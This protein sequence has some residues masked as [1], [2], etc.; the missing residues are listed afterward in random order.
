MTDSAPNSDDEEHA[1][2]YVGNVYSNTAT[3]PPLVRPAKKTKFAPWHHPVKQIVRDYQWGDLTFKL[4]QSREE[5]TRGTLRYF[6]L[7]GADLL[8]VRYLSK[9]LEA[10]NSK[11]E[12][13]GFN[14][15]QPDA[16]LSAVEAEKGTYFSAETALRQ[17]GKTTGNAVVLPD[18]LE[19]IANPSSQAAN[20]L[21]Q[22]GVFDV[23]NIDACSHLGFIPEGRTQS[24]F[25]AMGALLA[26]QL[27][28]EQPWLLFVTTRAAPDLL[29]AP[30]LTLQ[31][32][33]NDNIKL[34]PD[35]FGAAVAACINGGIQTLAGDLNKSWGQPGEAFLKVFVLGVAKYL[36]QFFHGQPN[37]QAK[38]ELASAYAYRV[39]GDEPDMLSLAF[40]ISPAGLKVHP[41]TAGGAVVG[42]SLELKAALAAVARVSNLWL[43]DGSLD[44]EEI[45]SDAVLGTV[46]LLSAADYDI[47]AWEAWLRTHKIRPMLI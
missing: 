4:V 13:F 34:H 35:E 10:H 3:S 40:R 9:K 17:A 46:D 38:V 21:R 33:I 47:E 11:I 2:D 22:Q 5:E 24:L 23:V 7:P 36:L 14:Q 45:K 25:D 30:A 44:D 26:H 39:H 20:R 29:G 37:L 32:A 31:S 41:P 12:Y 8:D 6:T 42:E 19:D 1:P 18:R 27:R 28:A 43:L 15:G 16:D